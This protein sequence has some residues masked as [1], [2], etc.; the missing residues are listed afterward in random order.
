[1]S[2]TTNRVF[3]APFTIL[4]PIRIALLYLCIGTG[5][6]LFSDTAA[7]WIVTDRHQLEHVG[8]VKGISF[9]IVTAGLLHLLIRNYARQLNSSRETYHQAEREIQ[10]LAYYDRETG[11]PN[12]NLLLDRLNQVIAFN[13]RKNKN[14]AVI[15]N[16][17]TG[18]KA[19]VDARGQCVGR[20][21]VCGLAHSMIGGLP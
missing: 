4:T 14:T 20:E 21:A 18:F 9:I 13:S 7:A 15:Y 8:V 10:K 16:N 11:L 6:I 2:V 3:S 5:W 19:V 12:H 17:L 1:M